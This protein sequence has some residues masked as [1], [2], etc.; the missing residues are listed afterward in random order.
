MP[1][2]LI[3]GLAFLG[4]FFM[5]GGALSDVDPSEQGGNF[6]TEFDS[7]FVLA[8]QKFGVPFALLKAHAIQE[9]S[10]NPQAIRQE[11]ATSSRPASA[12]YGLMQL[13]WWQGSERWS[14]F[15]VTDAE[16]SDGT[17]LY[18]P[19]TNIDLGAQ[20]IKANLRS[21]GGS[22]RDAINM[23]NAG[24][25]ESVREAPGNYVEKV[26]GYYNSILNKG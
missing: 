23:Y 2:L 19:Q 8:S 24:V 22:L 5:G 17:L 20:L 6:S 16:I 12:S 11:P 3:A 15:G 7:E 4:V 1:F 26:L 9:S 13:L 14:Q 21:C 18:D 25:K 10:L